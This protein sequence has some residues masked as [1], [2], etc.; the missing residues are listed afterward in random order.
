VV[1]DQLRG[2]FL[3]RW[4][5]LFGDG[6]FRRL[7]AD[8]AWFQNCHYPYAATMTGP[9]HASVVT[10]C[11]PARHGVVMNEWYD[12]AEGRPVYCVGAERHRQVPPQREPPKTA[13]AGA[14]P[15][16]GGGV[17][18][19]RLLAPSVGDALKA[20]TGGR[21]RVVAL[22][23]KDRSA[24]LLGG[25]RP[26]ACYWL[27]AADGA[28]VTSTYYRDRPHPWVEAFNGRRPADR[29]FGRDWTRL[30]PDLDYDRYSG[31]DDVAA[32]SRGV[33]Q[34]RTFPH[35]MTGGRTAPGAKYYEALYNSPFGNDLLLEL[36]QAAVDA[37]GLGTRE[38]PDLLCVSFSSNDAV[39]HCWGPDSHEVLDTTLRTDRLLRDLLVYL[40]ARVGRGRYVLALTADHGICPLP[41]VA[42]R[43]A[44]DAGFVA[45]GLL[46]R[47]ANDFLEET[48][49]QEGEKARWV[50]AAEYPW[51][52]LNQDLLR[53]RGLSRPEVEEALAGWLRRQAGVLAAYTRGQLDRG[54]PA[55]DAVGRAVARSYHPS[56]CG[57]VAVVLKPYYLMSA[58][59]TG[60]NHGSPH[61]YDTHVPLLV[62]GSG[63]RAA[64]RADRVTPQAV[65]A[66]LARALGVPPP[67][68]DAAPVPD[69]LFGGP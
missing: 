43:Q 50:E 64:V 6:G 27:D 69:G 16:P 57:D 22:S 51:V 13:K 41:D 45:P 20:A 61:P 53:R 15:P 34:G 14:G 36:A 1:I 42:R 40:D 18:P 37:E 8:G 35:A 12:R 5:D 54:V 29:W 25:R 39:G 67:A 58:K 23:W 32:E 44:H 62:Y 52:Y 2:D 63:V 19:E 65:A 28:A 33:A 7:Q 56:R 48:F 17:S 4:Q 55:G 10:G 66:I 60:T 38:A 47:L 26:D 59:L 9:G 24:A 21:A 68:D 30:R 11:S 31:P 3:M 49:D 46:D